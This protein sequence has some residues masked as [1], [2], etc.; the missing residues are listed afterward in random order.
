MKCESLF[1][2]KHDTKSTEYTEI[3]DVYCKNDNRNK[4][5]VLSVH[6]VHIVDTVR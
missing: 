3:V 4:R 6:I 1:D 5:R 2:S